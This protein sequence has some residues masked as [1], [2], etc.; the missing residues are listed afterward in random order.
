MV[1]ENCCLVPVHSL[2]RLMFEKDISVSAVEEILSEIQCYR[3][4]DNIIPK[5]VATFYTVIYWEAS[6]EVLI[7]F[8]DRLSLDCKLDWFFIS[9]LSR[10]TNYSIGLW[11]RLVKCGRLVTNY[12]K[13]YFESYRPNLLSLFD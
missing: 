11:G 12:L 13:S 6:E 5:E 8:L 4:E 9:E 2:K 10:S 7:H 3:V 1:A